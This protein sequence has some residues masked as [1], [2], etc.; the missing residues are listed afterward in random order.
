MRRNMAEGGEEPLDREMSLWET[1]RWGGTGLWRKLG[2]G[3]EDGSGGGEIEGCGIKSSRELG[4]WRGFD[5]HQE[6]DMV[7]SY[8]LRRPPN[9]PEEI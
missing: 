3:G 6:T 2:S 9:S 8:F 4:T 7:L 1:P 5:T